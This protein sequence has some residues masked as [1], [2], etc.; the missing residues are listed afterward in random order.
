MLSPSIWMS[1][2]RFRS[3]SEHVFVARFD[4]GPTN[5]EVRVQVGL[6]DMSRRSPR[7]SPI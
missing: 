3:T 6:R 1:D 2:T 7:S 4:S 5:G